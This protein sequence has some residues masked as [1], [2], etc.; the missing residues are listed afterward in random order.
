MLK[1]T[2]WVVTLVLLSRRFEKKVQV[3]NKTHK[4]ILSQHANH[5]KMCAL[6][7]LHTVIII[8]GVVIY[9]QVFFSS[10]WVN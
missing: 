8:D 10:R 4:T 9:F 3:T 5:T 2:L 1:W 6:N 7:K